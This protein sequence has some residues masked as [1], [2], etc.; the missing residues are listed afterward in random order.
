MPKEGGGH[1]YILAPKNGVP[2]GKKIQRYLPFFMDWFPLRNLTEDQWD[3]LKEDWI[4][5]STAKADS[6]F[7]GSTACV[8][9]KF[10]AFLCNQDPDFEA[11]ELAL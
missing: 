1:D 3:T 2:E 5:A 11:R 8:S 6:S 7:T 9:A 10:S 4:T